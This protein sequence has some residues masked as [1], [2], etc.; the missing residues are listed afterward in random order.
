MVLV[1]RVWSKPD[2]SPPSQRDSA[3]FEKQVL[4]P[5]HNVLSSLTGFL[6]GPTDLA[7]HHYYTST[8]LTVFGNESF[9]PLW[10][11]FYPTSQFET[12]LLRQVHAIHADLKE[13]PLNTPPHQL[14]IADVTSV[15]AAIDEKLQALKDET[16]SSLKSFADAV[17]APAPTNPPPP[18][19]PKPKN[20]PPSIKGN[21]LPQAVVRY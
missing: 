13:L 21:R 1:G 17:K 3:S 6:Q 18:H 8:I 14:P 9:K 4:E 7:L 10:P 2:N 20:Q 19:H 11:V 16:S 15:V 12:N 5:L